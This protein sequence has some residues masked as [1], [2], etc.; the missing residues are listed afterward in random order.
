LDEKDM[1]LL[2]IVSTIRKF[3]LDIEKKN[4]IIWDD[5]EF[6]LLVRK[7]ERKTN[8]YTNDVFFS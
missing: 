3:I 8:I 4:F 6:Y 1:G 2:Y 5:V 7:H